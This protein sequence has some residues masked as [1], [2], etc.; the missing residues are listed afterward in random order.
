MSR[1]RAA[2]VFMFL[3]VALSAGIPGAAF[4][5]FP[6]FF[7]APR[8]ESVLIGVLVGWSVMLVTFVIL[9][10]TMDKSQNVFL[11]GYVAGFLARLS[12]LGLA[13]LLATGGRHP[14]E[15]L[16]VS[17]AASYFLLFLVEAWILNGLGLP[18][19]RAKA[20]SAEG[21]AGEL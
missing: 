12:A 9:L 18:K 6:G 10:L 7:T 15:F 20:C 13:A 3:S 17:V 14:L 21:A 1:S 5:L 16:L 4:G 19:G 8:A 2:A 11:G